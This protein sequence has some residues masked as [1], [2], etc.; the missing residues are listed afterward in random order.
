MLDENIKDQISNGDNL[1]YI[2]GGAKVDKNIDEK[3]KQTFNTQSC[4]CGMFQPAICKSSIHICD[5]C[6]WSRAPKGNST[7]TYCLKQFS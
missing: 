2:S 5:N 6:K 3:Y 1:Y 4:N 7:I